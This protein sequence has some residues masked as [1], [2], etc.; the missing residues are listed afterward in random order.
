[1]VGG[2]CIVR[3]RRAGGGG[4][5]RGGSGKQPPGILLAPTLYMYI[6]GGPLARDSCS[7]FRQK[8]K[9]LR[10]SSL[11]GS[12]KLLAKTEATPT[13]A[14]QRGDQTQ[15]H[16]TACCAASLLAAGVALKKQPHHQIEQAC[17]TPPR[18]PPPPQLNS[19]QRCC[20]RASWRRLA[21]PRV[22]IPGRSFCSA[23]ARE[24]GCRCT[25]MTPISGPTCC[26]PLGPAAASKIRPQCF[27]AS[28][29]G[30]NLTRLIMKSHCYRHH[31][32]VPPRKVR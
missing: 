26:R 9:G 6:V 31:H 3:L 28:N 21:M 1:M 27:Y 22:G 25:S 19:N 17:A 24:R 30:A 4:R 15:Q 8:K 11:H 18:D 23:S 16:S 32:D 2:R 13:A 7:S 10:V 12:T 5:G 20:V 29:K 14:V